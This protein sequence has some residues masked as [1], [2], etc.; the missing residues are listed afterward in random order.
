MTGSEM[1]MGKR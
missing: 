1:R